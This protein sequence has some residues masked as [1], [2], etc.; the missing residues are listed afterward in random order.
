MKPVGWAVVGSSEFVQRRM[1]PA[2]SDSEL[3]VVHTIVSRS[4][5]ATRAIADKFGVPSVVADPA[6]AVADPAVEAVYI[7]TPVFLHAPQIRTCLQ[8]DKA[9]LCEKPLALNLA[10]AEEIRRDVRESGRLFMEGYMLR[11]HGAHVLARQIIDAGRLGQLTVAEVDMSFWYPPAGVW[12]QRWREGGGGGLMDVGSHAVHLVQTLVGRVRSV[13]AL[14][15]TQVHDYEV[16]DGATLLLGVEPNVHVV[17]R[18]AFNAR[19]GRSFWR[20]SGTLGQ[21][22]GIGTA[23]Q[24]PDGTLLGQFVNPDDPTAPTDEREL[25]YARVNTYKTMLETFCR[26][27]RTGQAASVNAIDESVSVMRVLDAAYRSSREARRIDL[28]DALSPPDR[29]RP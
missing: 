15:G 12:R 17:V 28:P 10:K 8:A 6:E 20:I 22:T 25:E 16:D 7:A 13:Q 26:A 4:P 18:S 3:A 9:V 2:M 19:P 27:L 11:F 14:V 23:G 5:E 1:L 29:A 21:L 24:S